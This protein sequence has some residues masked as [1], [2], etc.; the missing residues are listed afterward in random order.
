MASDPESITHKPGKLEGKG[1]VA[2]LLNN[3]INKA[4]S[5]I[6]L[7]KHCYVTSHR[8]IEDVERE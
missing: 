6:R 1:E 4:T 8:G 2:I 5:L 3:D 7:W